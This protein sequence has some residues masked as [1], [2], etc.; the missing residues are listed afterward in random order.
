MDAHAR[1]GH[2]R[3]TAVARLVP[4]LVGLVALMA[5]CAATPGA[6]GATDGTTAPAVR[7]A[8]AAAEAAQYDANTPPEAAQMICS[9]E[10]RGE[11]ADALGLTSDPTVTSGWAEH[12]YT[13]TY[14]VPMGQLV[15]AVSVSPSAAAA[16]G[17]LETLRGRLGA[18][19]QE[20]GLGEQAYSAAA[21]TVLAVKDNMV[22]W[23]NATGL[24][25]DLGVVH[26]GRLD[27]AR[28]IAAGVFNCWIGNS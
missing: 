27:L 2:R 24:P 23:V 20:A 15:L 26:E 21:G 12:V 3:R 5:G 25:D 19:T 1:G 18:D 14:A 13:C 28:V 8:A 10:I 22:L 9:D 11:V 4:A 17:Q 6:P 16:R 7:S